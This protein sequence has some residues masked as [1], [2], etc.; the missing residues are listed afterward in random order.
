MYPFFKIF[1]IH[2]FFIK[3]FFPLI[4]LNKLKS[5]VGSL[6]YQVSTICIHINGCLRMYQPTVT[7][8]VFMLYELITRT[9]VMIWGLKYNNGSANYNV[10]V[11][12]KNISINVRQVK[13]TVWLFSSLTSRKVVHH[14]ISYKKK[15]YLIRCNASRSVRFAQNIVLITFLKCLI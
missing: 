5:Q 3:T 12:T 15:L 8:F 7:D 2:F 11:F 6:S 10:I 14:E 4:T 13:N 1:T 9:M